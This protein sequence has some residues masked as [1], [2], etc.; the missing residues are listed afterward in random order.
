MQLEASNAEMEKLARDLE[1]EKAKTEALLREMLPAF[2][3]T[4]LING[5]TVDACEYRVF[6]FELC[7]AWAQLYLL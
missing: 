5:K 6:E 2:V 4:Q 7:Q 1:G 3:A